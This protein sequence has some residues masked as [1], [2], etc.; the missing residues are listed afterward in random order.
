MSDKLEKSACLNWG[1][2]ENYTERQDFYK[3][4]TKHPG[5]V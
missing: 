5:F 1:D 3:D 4:L 2:R